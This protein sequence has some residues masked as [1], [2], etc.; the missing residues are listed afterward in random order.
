[1]ADTA[2]KLPVEAQA[3]WD[4][5]QMMGKSK[6]EYF[7]L[8]QEIDQKYKQGGSPTIAENLQLEKL[9]KTHG[10]KVTSFNEAMQAVTDKTAREL[11]LKKLMGD[12]SPPGMH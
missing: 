9:L 2:I 12:T 7:G 3:A 6:I 4:A 8:L 10:E 1:M 5:Y 11:L